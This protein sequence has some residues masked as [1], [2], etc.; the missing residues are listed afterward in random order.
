MPDD[1]DSR[2][3]QELLDQPFEG[4]RWLVD[5]LI[6]YGLTVFAG[7]PKVGKSW[8]ALQ[9]ALSVSQGVPFLGHTTARVGTL[10]LGLEDTYRRIQQRLFCLTDIASE[11]LHFATR[12]ERVHGGLFGQLEAFIKEHKDTRLVIIDTLQ[13]VRGFSRDNLYAT[14]YEELGA[15]K[16]FA[17]DWGLAVV[18]VHHTRKMR[19]ESDAF[20]NISGSNAV[21]GAADEALVL[22]K[23]DPFGTEA[24]LAVTGRDVDLAEY[25]LARKGYGWELVGQTSREELRERSIPPA[26]LV[27][28]DF[29]ANRAGSW[30]G[31]ATRLIEEAGVTGIK[32]NVL[33][34]H[35]NEHRGFLAE[36]GIVYGFRRTGSARLISLSKTGELDAGSGTGDAG[37]HRA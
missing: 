16:R 12:A 17:D 20:S 10:Y 9:L 34:K 13:A 19:D 24:T 8:M 11:N 29:A 6:S 7:A 22:T 15:I 5:G 1:L 31:T 18:V 2:T 23:S 4:A 3:A 26:V 27:V 28:L 33:A 21:L 32:A 25:R 36:R 14:D 37:G 35:L 30:E